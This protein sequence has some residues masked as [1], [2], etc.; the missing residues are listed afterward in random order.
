[1]INLHNV[2]DDFFIHMHLPHGLLAGQD[3]LDAGDRFQG[4]NRMLRLEPLQHGDFDFK[5]RVAQTQPDE[6]P[7]QL[8]LGQRETCLRDQSDFA[9][10]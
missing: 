2:A 9:W 4:F 6:E 8:R 3:F 5:L 7:V 10:R 1:M